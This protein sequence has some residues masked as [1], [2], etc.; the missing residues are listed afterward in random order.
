MSASMKTGYQNLLRLVGAIDKQIELLEDIQA[1]KADPGDLDMF[2]KLHDLTRSAALLQAEIRKTG[3]DA[4][5][6]VAK[7]SDERK[8]ELILGMIKAMSPEYRQAVADYCEELGGK[9]LT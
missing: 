5:K 6:A 9:V 4:E 7:L 8:V 1:G 3:Q 2:S